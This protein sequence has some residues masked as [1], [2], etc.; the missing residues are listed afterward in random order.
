VRSLKWSR[1]RADKRQLDLRGYVTTTADAENKFLEDMPGEIKEVLKW[2][3]D[4]RSSA[5]PGHNMADFAG[6]FLG[7]MYEDGAVLPT[8]LSAS[9]PELLVLVLM[10]HRTSPR[11]TGAWL[12]LGFALRRVALYRTQ[13][14]EDFNRTRLESALLAFDRALQ[15]ER[16]NKGKNIRVWTG[17]SFVYHML[18]LY[19]EELECCS[20][21][22]GADRS[23]PK[24]WLLYGFALRSAGRQDQALLI[25]N[26]AYDA[27]VR[28]GKPEALR[29]AF[30]DVQSPTQR[31]CRQRME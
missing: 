25:M 4:A 30:A 29:E 18:G 27:Y 22:L 1:L 28:A 5:P 3:A 14:P 20:R 12:N 10:E 7:A 15:L 9:A 16:D 11:S 24:L 23:D 31:P 26:D 17:M 21:A 13:D 19:G 2:Y 8:N 6:W